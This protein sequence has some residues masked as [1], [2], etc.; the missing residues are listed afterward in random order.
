MGKANKKVKQCRVPGRVSG[1]S[2]IPSIPEVQLSLAD[3]EGDPVEL[4]MRLEEEFKE[5]GGVKLVASREWRP[6][7][8]FRFGDRGITT[9]IQHLHKLGRGKVQFN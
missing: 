4:L 7:F 2:K 8:S 6:P 1:Y 9:R 3:M 5:Y